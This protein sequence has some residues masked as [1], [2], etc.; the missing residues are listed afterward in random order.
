MDSLSVLRK[1]YQQLNEEVGEA[2]TESE[3]LSMLRARISDF[4]REV[5]EMCSRSWK[6][7]ESIEKR[8]G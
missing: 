6:M 1:R 7:K 8:C 4:D 2:E 3:T 5:R